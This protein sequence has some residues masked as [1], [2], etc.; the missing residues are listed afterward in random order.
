VPGVYA[1][2]DCRRGQSLI[3]WGIQ[4]RT[5]S[6]QAKTLTNFH[7]GGTRCRRRRRRVL[8]PQDQPAAR[9]R[10][11]QA[12]RPH[13]RPAAGADG[14]RGPGLSLDREGKGSTKGS[15]SVP[16]LGLCFSPVI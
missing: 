13:A 3:V 1:A 2:G 12:S 10:V 6:E 8:E 14:Q 11:F 7:A 16:R 15:G 9:R 4:V 5:A